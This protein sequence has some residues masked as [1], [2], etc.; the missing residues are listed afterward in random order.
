M[1]RDRYGV[2]EVE[3]VLCFGRDDVGMG[4]RYLEEAWAVRTRFLGEL[5][6]VG[7]GLGID[8]GGDCPAGGPRQV[9]GGGG[10]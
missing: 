6:E 1:I 9:G 2:S 5:A 7:G 10:G 8:G 4:W 3:D